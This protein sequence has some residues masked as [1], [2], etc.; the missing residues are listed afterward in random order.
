MHFLYYLFIFLILFSFIV[1]I[2]L[3]FLNVRHRSR[4]I[5]D[6]LKD[7]YPPERYKIQQNYDVENTKFNLIQKSLGIL[8]I[9]GVIITG[10]FGWLHG[11]IMQFNFNSIVTTVLFFTII[12]AISSII[13]LPFSVW[14]T[15]VIEERYGFNKTSAKLFIF[16]FIKSLLLTIIVGG[17]LLVLVTW[18]FYR[19][20]DWFWILGLC[21]MVVFS[22]IANVLYSKVIV[23]L[24]NKQEPLEEGNL[25]ESI[26][27]F[28]K[29]VGFPL[30]KVFVIDGSKRSTKANAY[31][32]GFGK[33]RRV[34]LFDTLIEKLDQKEV[35]AVLAHEIGHYRRR[36]IWINMTIGVVQAAIFMYLFSRL[37]TNTEVSGAL[38]YNDA[39]EPIFHL[40]II[41][42]AILYSPIESI[43][44]LFTHWLSRRME[45]QADAFATIHGLGNDLINGLKKISAENLSNLT[46]HPTYVF[47]NY[48]HPTLLQRIQKIL[49]L[50]K[51]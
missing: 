34:V 4:P 51:N 33:S 40:A 7:V 45:Y 14:D 32:T 8:L 24:F 43:I 16:D 37:S 41:G 12:G 20:G 27:E 44:G 19:T 29:K 15:F 35:L 13:S 36:H 5:P 28:G 47:V 1:E 48:S 9:L 50:N 6:L 17:G 31:F 49:T 2:F 22:F 18:L 46:P 30:N 23:P 10:G 38:G 11:W 26:K 3:D 39:S 42:F 25:L 21:V